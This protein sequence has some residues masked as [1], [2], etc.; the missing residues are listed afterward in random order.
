MPTSNKTTYIKNGQPVSTDAYP[1]NK[2]VTWPGIK[3]YHEMLAYEIPR[4]GSN[5]RIGAIAL[6]SFSLGQSNTV[7]GASVASFALGSGNTVTGSYSLIAGYGNSIIGSSVTAFGRNLTLDATQNNERPLLMIGDGLDISDE[8]WKGKQVAFAIG[9][10]EKDKNAKNLIIVTYD[11]KTVINGDLTVTGAISNSTTEDDPKAIKGKAERS[12]NYLIGVTYSEPLKKMEMGQCAIW[13]I[14]NEKDSNG[15]P[16]QENDKSLDGCLLINAKHPKPEMA[17]HTIK[18]YAGSVGSYADIHCKDC[19]CAGL[20]GIKSGVIYSSKEVI[21]FRTGPAGDAGYSDL[22]CKD[23]ECS[24][25]I[26]TKQGVIY[27]SSGN[28]RFQT[29]PGNNTKI[30]LECSQLR[31]SALVSTDKIEGTTGK[32]SNSFSVGS[33]T[34]GNTS[35]SIYTSITSQKVTSRNIEAEFFTSTADYIE[36]SLATSEHTLKPGIYVIL[37]THLQ[38]SDWYEST[39]TGLLVISPKSSFPT[40]LTECYDDDGGSYYELLYQIVPV[41]NSTTKK[42]S[43]KVYSQKK[44]GTTWTKVSYGTFRIQPLMR[45]PED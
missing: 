38:V 20:I 26:G 11:G 13:S 21:Q 19:E 44:R 8:A 41:Y 23:V 42:Y 29:S 2:M 5:N 10:K 18:F 35:T 6:Y 34:V 14:A 12:R 45:L 22:Y 32:I 39:A 31:C 1:L 25:M 4:L 33:L 16:L 36:I 24:G 30:N 37:Y 28:I 3:K 15:N 43:F 9:G 40:I 7:T 27:S 17:P